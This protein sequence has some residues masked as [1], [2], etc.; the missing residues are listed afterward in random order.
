MGGLE[1][2][3]FR[4][5]KVAYEEAARRLEVAPRGQRRPSGAESALSRGF[6]EAPIR[7]MW[8]TEGSKG[9][10]LGVRVSPCARTSSSAAG[11]RHGPVRRP[12]AHQALARRMWPA[13]ARR[14]TRS[15]PAIWLMSS[16]RLPTCKPWHRS[17]AG[18]PRP[19]MA[20]GR[21]RTAASS[22]RSHRTELI[23]G[24]TAANV[25]ADQFAYQS[26]GGACTRSFG[27]RMRGCSP[28]SYW[29]SQDCSPA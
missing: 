3:F 1:R 9:E 26:C 21:Y 17:S 12:T 10:E 15:R 2:R 25:A 28:S 16:A 22:T 24:S 14:W 8:R 11:R 18:S 19:A 20:V 6:T 29:S 13:R 7:P 4:V 23:C 5:R 27:S